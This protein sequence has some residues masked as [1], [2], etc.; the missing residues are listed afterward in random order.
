MTIHLLA[1]TAKIGQYAAGLLNL[2]ERPKLYTDEHA[3]RGLQFKPGDLF[4]YV[5]ARRLKVEVTAKMYD[6]KVQLA[7]ANIPVLE[8]TLP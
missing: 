1:A 5:H 7:L 4:I 8:L 2:D 6:C 3:M